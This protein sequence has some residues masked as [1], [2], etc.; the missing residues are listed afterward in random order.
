MPSL[1][2]IIPVDPKIKLGP[3]GHWNTA[4]IIR[5]AQLPAAGEIKPLGGD[6]Q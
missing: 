4:I 1:F 5:I 2:Y 3:M 6:W